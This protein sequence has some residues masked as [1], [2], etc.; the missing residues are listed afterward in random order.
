MSTYLTFK[1]Q[2]RL[3]KPIT[4]KM[5][6]PCPPTMLKHVFY[7]WSYLTIIIFPIIFEVVYVIF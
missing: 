2:G 1:L 7:D 6:W 3:P 4:L 5:I